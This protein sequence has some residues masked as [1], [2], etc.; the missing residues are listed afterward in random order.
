MSR[1]CAPAPREDEQVLTERR[2]VR[3]LSIRTSVW[4]PPP[5]KTGASGTRVFVCLVQHFSRA[6]CALIDLILQL[7]VS[8]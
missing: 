8:P 1:F 5:K 3:V 2:F 4:H 7:M 6:L